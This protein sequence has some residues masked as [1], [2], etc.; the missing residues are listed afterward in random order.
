MVSPTPGQIYLGYWEK[1]KKSW[2][3]LL[4][5]TANLEDVGVPETLEDLKLLKELPPCYRYDATTKTLEWKEGFEDGG[6]KV[7]QR[8]FPVM[9]FDDGLEF[10]SESDV[11]W[12]PAHHLEVFDIESA[13]A[14]EVPHIRSVQAYL[15]ARSGIPSGQDETSEMDVDGGMP[16]SCSIS[17]DFHLF[18]NQAFQM[19]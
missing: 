19:L 7:A 13:L 2:P 12:L 17:C 9:V 4:L 15:R 8:Q 18:A 1:A 14:S 6:Q 11:G 10:P 5:P 3:V 16:C